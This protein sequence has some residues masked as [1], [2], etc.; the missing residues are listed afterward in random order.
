MSL[1]KLLPVDDFAPL[2][3][4]ERRP[5]TL[6]AF[7]TRADGSI[8]EL[9][10]SDLSHDGCGVLSPVVLRSGE[11]LDLAV[12]R[13][14]TTPA[15]VR[16]YGSGRAGLTFGEEEATD[17][18]P[19]IP[20]RHERVSVDGEAWMRRS[21][22]HHFRVHIYDLS[23]HGCKAEFVERPEIGEQLWIKF[24]QLEA[25]EAEVRW[26]AGPRTGVE[27]KQPIHQAVFDLLVARHG[28]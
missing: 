3:R 24:E 10:I 25:L 20:R 16:W 7:A 15:L 12:A 28:V 4:R 6:K 18:P 11:Q 8:V 21:A 19:Q 14:G 2:D 27:F 26:I 17:A 23:P 22:K 5:V 1:P 9:T 13:R